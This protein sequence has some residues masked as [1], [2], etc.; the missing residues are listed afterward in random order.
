M[1]AGDIYTVAGSGRRGYSGDSGDASA[2][3]LA[4]MPGSGAAV[5]ESG[6]LV[7]ADGGNNRLRVVAGSTGRF[8]GQAM[9][10]GHIYTIAG[11]GSAG[12]SGDGGPAA[13]AELDQPGALVIDRAG[14]LLVADTLNRRV[15]AIADGP[16]PFYGRPMVAG[17]IDTVAG[18]GDSHISGDGAPATKAQLNRP[19][20]VAA[21]GAGSFA[22]A[23][24]LGNQVRFVPKSTGQFYGQAMTAGDIYLVAGNGTVGF[25]GDGGHATAG[26]LASPSGVALD[27]S[28]N[29]V[30]ADTGN[31]R[32]RVVAMSSGTFYGLAMIAGYIYT[33]AGNGTS[34][35]SGDGGPA[36]AAQLSGPEGVAANPSSNLVVADTSN[37]VIRVVAASTGTF[38]G[39]P[40]TAGDIYT[41]AGGGSAG[42]PS[43]GVPAPSA[44]LRSPA[45]VGVDLVGNLTIADTLDNRVRVVAA[46]S[47]NFYGQTM[48]AGAIA[49]VAGTGES[50]G[51]LGDGGLG[52][53][54]EVSGPDGVASDQ[55]GNLLI[56]DT[57][58][59][60]IRV[61]AASTGDF[62]GQAMVAGYIYT[63][64]GSRLS[65]GYGGDGGSATHAE[66]SAP[67]A[68]A[69]TGSGDV[70][71]ADGR[72]H[73]VRRV[74]AFGPPVAVPETRWAALFPIF[75]IL[76]VG[77]ALGYRRRVRR[78]ELSR[79][80][81]GPRRGEAGSA[82]RD[83]RD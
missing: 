1:T 8:Y 37:H 66:L 2:A 23:D 71:I 6:N 42:H 48:T 54:G 45:A 17:S 22:I 63:V 9:T 75:G 70:L 68:V 69:V 35:F 31:N 27:T 26:R 56:A 43:D 36:S 24:D 15:R 65:G 74:T 73:R 52:T 3:D 60:R 62:Y 29:I 20:A 32:V 67:S 78:P 55:E 4:L 81:D 38:Y 79:P 28:A 44:P 53:A 82:A 72:S 19:R 16:G 12:F 83:R 33:V 25:G 77:C 7:V 80:T 49:T 10:V 76:I 11:R 58:H 46:S 34:G 30:V 51:S 61:V 47:G 64:A 50:I 59:N 5:D 39:R 21:D 41:V 14:N 18:N 57:G 13:A 40:M